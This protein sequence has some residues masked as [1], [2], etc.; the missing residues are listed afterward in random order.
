MSDLNNVFL[1]GN[2]TGDAEKTSCKSGQYCYKFSI[3][4][5]RNVKQ[6][7]TWEKETSFIPVVYFSKLTATFLKGDRVMLSG[8]LRENVWQDK[9]GQTHRQ[10]RVI[11][12][13]VDKFVREKKEP[14]QPTLDDFE[15]EPPF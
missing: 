9:E 10:L 12:D 11:A 14:V 15:D 7:E 3:A 4:V 1:Q 13:R 2:L 8:S 6:G 5:G